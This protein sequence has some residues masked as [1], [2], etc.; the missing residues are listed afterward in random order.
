[1]VAQLGKVRA[2]PVV[3]AL[4]QRDRRVQVRIA[5][6]RLVEDAEVIAGGLEMPLLLD[7][8]HRVESWRWQRL[9]LRHP[10]HRA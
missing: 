3:H 8:E 5:A 4:H 1:M 7:L 9:T 6:D 2:E 10:R